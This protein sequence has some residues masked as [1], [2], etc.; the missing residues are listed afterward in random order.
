[1]RSARKVEA[2]PSRRRAPI[3]VAHRI[4][5]E[6]DAA[7][8]D[9]GR[10][11]D[12][13][14]PRLQRIERLDERLRIGT[15]AGEFLD[16]RQ[17]VERLGIAVGIFAGRQRA[18]LLPPLAAG[19]VGIKL[20][21]HVG[22]RRQRHAVDQHLAQRASADRKIG[23]RIE[24]RDDGVDQRRIVGRKQAEGIADGVVE[25]ARRQIELDVPGFLFGA[26][27]VEQRARQRTSRSTGLSREQPGAACD[28]GAAS[29]GR[30]RRRR[31]AWR[32]AILSSS[33]SVLSMRA[34]SLPP[35]TH[36]FSRSS[37]PRK[38]APE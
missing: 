6:R 25:A 20:E 11:R 24:R 29:V 16:R 13:I 36:R 37:L 5:G 4:D 27:L 33:C 8:R 10:R 18:R 2:T 21:Q 38:I 35:G 1:M 32:G 17:H 3:V 15:D 12:R 7:G 26:R 22:R 14:K 30:L 19:D 34:V 31:P 28:G 9:L 23:R